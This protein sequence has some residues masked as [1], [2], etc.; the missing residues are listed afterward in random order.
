MISRKLNLNLCTQ[1]NFIFRLIQ[2][3]KTSSHLIAILL[4]QSIKINSILITIDVELV[5]LQK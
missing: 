3:R 1:L 2:L 5:L 4:N